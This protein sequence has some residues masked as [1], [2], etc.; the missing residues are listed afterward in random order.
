[1]TTEY[2][3]LSFRLNDEFVDQYR[4]REI[5]WG[6]DAGAGNTLGELTWLTKYSRVK[7]DGTKETWVDGCRRVIEGVY[8]ILK[9]H[10]AVNKT[11]WNHA[12][13][14]RAAEDAFERMFMFKWTPPGRGLWM[15]GTKFVWSEGSA[16]LQNCAFVSTEHL[17]VR[18]PTLPFVRLMEM[19]MLGIGVGFDTEGAGNLTFHEP[20]I[21]EVEEFVIPDSREGWCEATD[22]VLR[23]YLL[24]GQ[25]RVVFDYSEV[26]PAGQ[27]IKRFGGVANGPESLMKLHLRL[28]KTLGGREG[29]SMTSTDIVDIMTQIGKCVVAGN[30]RRSAEVAFG[31]ADDKDFLD[32]K[33]PEINPERMG[34]DGWGFMSNNSVMAEVGGNYDHLIDR[35]AI[36]GEPGLNYLDL[37]RSHGRLIDPPNNRD[38]RAKGANPCVE[39]TLEDQELCTLIETY[40]IKHS[41]LDDYLR[42]LKVAYLYG[43][44]VTLLSTHWPESN[45]VMQRNR[46]I[47]TSVSGIAQFIEARGW[48]ELRTWMDEGYQEITRRDIQYS[49]WLGVRESIKTTSVKPSGTVSLLVGVTPGVHWPEH[50]VYLRRM[51]FYV[52]DP[53]VEVFA[54]AGYSVEPD[55]MDKDNTVVVTF[56]TR[57]PHVRHNKDVSVW[58]K[59]SLAVT[60]QKWWADNQVSATFT[61]RQDEKDQIGPLI[62]AFDGQ[63]KSMSF[64][65]MLEGGAYEQMPYEAIDL[66]EWERMV[67]SVKRMD[68]T[69]IY[70]NGVDP[71]G[72]RYCNNDYCEVG[73]HHH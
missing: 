37:A 64:L 29:Q 51:R 10:C 1:M 28:E 6:F 23:S 13:A 73:D 53:M 71:E 47:G 59:V 44:A 16:G 11:P 52:H 4:E 27:P 22:K 38:Y 36:N 56:P 24:P 62:H 7:E 60:M 26:R 67:E 43:K 12:K 39:Q 72:D 54:E 32:L 31:S 68:M 20:T 48:E 61:F 34:H 66:D 5:K 2:D 18:N 35:I 45:E 9:D 19:S 40:P 69:V 65:P 33:D 17:G 30:V 25:K 15:M 41:S 14:H 8:S 3:H 21:E 63:L 49:E 42:T 58:E 55:V 46:R 50:D 57:G 70:Q